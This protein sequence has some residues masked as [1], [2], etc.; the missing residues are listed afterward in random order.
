MY[1]EKFKTTFLFLFFLFL[2]KCNSSNP[3]QSI[4]SFSHEVS[5]EDLTNTITDSSENNTQGIILKDTSEVLDF[6]TSC[7]TNEICMQSIENPGVCKKVICDKESCE[8]KIVDAPLNSECNDNDPCTKDDHCDEQGVCK[9]NPISCDTPPSNI[10]IDDFT[11][12]KYEKVGECK[13][14]V[15]NYTFQD[16]KCDLGCLNGRCRKDFCDGLPEGSPCDDGN[17]CT[18]FDKCSS[19]GV[20]AGAEILCNNPPED[21]CV[22]NKTLR[23]FAKNG[24]CEDGECSF[25]HEDI[26]CELGCFNG[27]CKKSICDG[28]IKGTPCDD[29]NPCTLNDQC[30]GL[31]GCSGTPMECITP[32]ENFCVDNYTLRKFSSPEK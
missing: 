16:K 10:C 21:F 1:K 9:G 27:S 12:R 17:P 28:E 15:C 3:T 32:P 31:G 30:D 20:C 22:D 6:E 25:S 18:V 14:G 24:V 23:K 19:D 26:S 2:I 7:C 4:D 29:G 13:D 8:C 11:L 5:G